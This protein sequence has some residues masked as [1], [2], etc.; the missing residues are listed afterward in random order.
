[1]ECGIAI[2]LV[3]VLHHF[4]ASNLPSVVTVLPLDKHLVLG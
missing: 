2:K 3:T 4:I 1:M